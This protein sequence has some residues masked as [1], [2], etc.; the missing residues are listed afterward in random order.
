MTDAKKLTPP[1]KARCQSE[2]KNG[3]FTMGG[4]I[5]RWIRCTNAPTVIIREREAGQD[6]QLGE[7]SLCAECL[8][9]A[10][11]QLGSNTFEISVIRGRS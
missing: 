5:G 4:T 1:D 8:E 2:H 3:P 9:I 7:M 6:G 11:K 10:K